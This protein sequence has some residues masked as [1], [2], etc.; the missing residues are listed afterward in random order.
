VCSAAFSTDGSL[1]L[2]TSDDGTARIWDTL[3]GEC[4]QILYGT[5]T[6][7]SAVFEAG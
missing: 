2:T 7:L 6:V 1:V 5:A 4:T 3:T